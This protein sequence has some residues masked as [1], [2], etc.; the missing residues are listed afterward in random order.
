MAQGYFHCWSHLVEWIGNISF[1]DVSFSSIGD[2]THIEAE[3]EHGQ[4]PGIR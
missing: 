2:S 3:Q 1:V 4:F